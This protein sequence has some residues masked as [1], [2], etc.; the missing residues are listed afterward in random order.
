VAGFAKNKCEH[1]PLSAYGFFLMRD[2]KG[3]LQNPDE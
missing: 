2:K 1:S 3:L